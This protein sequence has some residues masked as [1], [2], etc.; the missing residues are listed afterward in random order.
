MLW[1][2]RER[3]VRY[4]I[5]ENEVFIADLYAREDLQPVEPI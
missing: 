3:A 5:L 1:D 4:Q 2:E